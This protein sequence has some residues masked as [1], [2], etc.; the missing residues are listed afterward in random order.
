[1]AD[2]DP[3]MAA[4][5]KVMKQEEMR[6]KMERLNRQ[7]KQKKDD[8][9]TAVIFLIVAG[10]VSALLQLIS[11][12]GRSW[13]YKQFVGM[14]IKIFTIRSSLFWISIDIE[15]GKNWLEDGLCKVGAR[16]NGEFSLHEGV[17][18][19]CSAAGPTACDVMNRMYQCSFIMFITYLFAIL[20][21]LTGCFFLRY[22]WYVEHR[23][24]IRIWAQT[25][26]M[27]APVISGIGIVAWSFV[28]PDLGEL[29]RSWNAYQTAMAGNTL[30][31]YHEVHDFRYGSSWAFAVVTW[32]V[33]SL[34]LV[35]WPAFFQKHH[36]EEG[37]EDEAER[38]KYEMETSLLQDQAQ[39]Y[40]SSMG[41]GMAGQG[42]W[43]GAP[44]A[45][46]GAY[47]AAPQPNPVQ[48]ARVAAT[49]QWTW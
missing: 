25:M 47:G 8:A 30:F 26:L 29:P 46:A 16:M 6:R 28:V 38:K 20:C 39:A 19:A 24:Q 35:V 33:S 9:Q 5:E 21:N 15:C 40:A 45:A 4:M 48:P 7:E 1:M 27:L 17:G 14:G 32:V 11:V 37:A 23:A 42:A 10:L 36:E 22:Y 31:G 41:A 13:S 2:G 18:V 43:P 12:F 49:Y 34:L 44:G 3:A